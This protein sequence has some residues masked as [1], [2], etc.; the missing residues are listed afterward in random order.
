MANIYSLNLSDP[1]HGL[2]RHARFTFGET[3]EIK[4]LEQTRSTDPAAVYMLGHAV[5]NAFRAGPEEKILSEKE[6][7]EK[8]I[9]A[10]NGAPTLLIIDAC[11]AESF[12]DVADVEWP[13]TFGFIFSSRSF[14]RS[15]HTGDEA[16][17]LFSAALNEAV[18]A[19]RRASSFTGLGNELSERLGR[20][21]TPAVVAS[22]ELLS[23]VL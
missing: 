18:L 7:A 17:S 15:W 16:Q 21:Q 9:S 11:F 22:E 4:R 2:L 3:I 19:C 20:I 23:A 6:V 12:L 10:R 8:L 13:K 14:E 1:K 5:P